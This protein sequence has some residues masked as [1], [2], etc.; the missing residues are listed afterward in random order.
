MPARGRGLGAVEGFQPV[1]RSLNTRRVCDF[2]SSD[3]IVC[4][5]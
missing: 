1:Q 2:D 4:E 3:N 5:V